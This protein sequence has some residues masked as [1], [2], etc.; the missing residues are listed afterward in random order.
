VKHTCFGRGGGKVGRKG[1][2]K[3]KKIQAEVKGGN[4]A[5]NRAGFRDSTVRQ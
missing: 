2:D 1:G 5:I 4:R 3:K